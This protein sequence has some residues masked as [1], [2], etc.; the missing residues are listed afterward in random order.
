LLSLNGNHYQ[1]RVADDSYFSFLFFQNKELLE[2]LLLN[3]QFQQL[4]GN[5]LGNSMNLGGGSLGSSSLGGGLTGGSFGSSLGGGLTGGSFGSGLGR[6]L[7]SG[8]GQ[9]DLGL[10]LLRSNSLLGRGSPS[11]S[12]NIASL[13]NGMTAPRPS[14]SRKILFIAVRNV[15]FHVRS[16]LLSYVM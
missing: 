12:L 16:Y 14:V 1:R 9:A 10:N 13:L 4:V 15:T 2:R 3:N 8:V 5:G 6:G 11:S 7:M